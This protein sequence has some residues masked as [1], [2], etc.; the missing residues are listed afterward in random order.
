MADERFNKCVNNVVSID[1][2]YQPGMHFLGYCD[3]RK[4]SNF[5]IFIYLLLLLL[6][7]CIRHT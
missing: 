2:L 5:Y 7:Y 3:L 4:R 6:F 1:T